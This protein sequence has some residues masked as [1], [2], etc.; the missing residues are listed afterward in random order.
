MILLRGDLEALN[1]HWAVAAV[2][3]SDKVRAHDVANARL[4]GDALGGQLHL[5]F[6]EESSDPA[7][8]E[9]LAMAYEVAA[10]EGLDALLSPSPRTRL[11]ATQAQAGAFRAF[12]IRR[13]CPIPEGETNRV[14]HVLHLA[15][16]AYAGDRW[17][18]LRRWLFDHGEKVAAPNAAGAAWDQRVLF[19][20]YDGWL[21][22]FRKDS[23]N[24]LH[25]IAEIV[26]GLRSE[27]QQY[28]KDQLEKGSVSENQ[29][30]ALRL[31]ALYHWARATERLSRF[32]LQGEPSGIS[33]EL[34]LHFEKAQQAASASFDMPLEMLLRWLHVAGR[35]MIAGSLWT[36]TSGINSKV[37]DFVQ[38]VTG[39]ARPMIELLPPNGRPWPSKDCWIRRPGRSSSTCRLPAGRRPWP[40]SAYSRPLTSSPK[41][42]GGSHMWPQLAL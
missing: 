23:W 39:Q 3:G 6:R 25:G 34:D 15:S 30:M 40:S 12:E 18:D 28:E 7:L 36:A 20:V 37:R 21:R 2:R 19:R 11:L 26:A 41:T 35:R 29:A 4:I 17:A 33:E 27:Q 24:D 8:L 38:K 5:D 42:R 22:L 32:M 13:I 14:F 31:V 16:L 10:A 9:R 1:H